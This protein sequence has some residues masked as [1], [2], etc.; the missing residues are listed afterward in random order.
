MKVFMQKSK[1]RASTERILITMTWGIGDAII[2]GLSAVDQIT[3]NDPDGKIAI[4]LLCNHSQAEL[5]K[6]DPRIH[7]VIE[8]DQRLFP[9][10][11]AG[12]WKRGI[13]LPTE[14]MKLAE[15]LR[16]QDY[17][18]ILPY[19]CAPTFFYRLHLPI[20]FLNAWESWKVILQMHSCQNMPLQMLI[21]GM[22]NKYFGKGLQD[23]EAEVPIPLYIRPEHIQQARH[24]IE[25]IK[26]NAFILQ[27]QSQLLLVAPDTS[28]EITRPPTRLLAEGIAWALASDPSLVV[29]ILPSY[30]KRAA[31]NNLLHALAPSFPGRIFLM[32]AEPK[33]SLLELAALID[34]SD[35]FISGDTGIMHIA[36]TTKK[37]KQEFR[38]EL[39]P[40]NSVKIITLFG[41]TSPAWF[42]YSKRAIILGWGRKEQA[43]FIP[44]MSK[45]SYDPKGKDL[46][47]HISSQE[48]TEAILS[49]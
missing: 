39:L 9:T 36:A 43:R 3:R 15:F 25:Q 21:R 19:I 1:S 33:H 6:E 49:H 41:G 45:D 13:F 27:E 48:L 20:L 4:D 32:P 7:Q 18:A 47:D 22:I 28:S 17:S 24:E 30:T 8:V 11:E 34:Q 46:F 38:E 2:I 37:I 12:T 23:L 5:L 31:S 29:V 35:L 16:N 44:G 40:R 42:G 26:Q 10:S 14:V